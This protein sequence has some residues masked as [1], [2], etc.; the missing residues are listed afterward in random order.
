MAFDKHWK[1]HISLQVCWKLHT[2]VFVHIY[3]TGN[4]SC[5]GC[6]Q[7]SEYTTSLNV[8]RPLLSRCSNCTAVFERIEI[9]III[10]C[11]EA[12]LHLR[13]KDFAWYLNRSH[14]SF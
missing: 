3:C 10:V 12:Y 7:G 6:S 2:P 14:L 9:R 4:M 1:L 8:R 11:L 5:F 13:F